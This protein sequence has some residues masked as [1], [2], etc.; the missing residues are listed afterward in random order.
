MFVGCQ[1]D[2]IGSGTADTTQTSVPSGN[3][4]NG[5]LLSLQDLIDSP[6]VQNGTTIYLSQYNVT[7]FSANIN[8]A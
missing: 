5:K 3:D 1:N 8:K 6:D 2:I 4:N 7:D